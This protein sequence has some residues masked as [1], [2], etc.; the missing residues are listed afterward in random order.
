MDVLLGMCRWWTYT[1][2]SGGESCV[3][4]CHS[5][6]LPQAPCACLLCVRVCVRVYVV[7]RVE[8]HIC[9]SHVHA[10]FCCS[11]VSIVCRA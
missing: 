7:S 11:K 3:K 2:D 5:T 4:F 8:I 1:G 10:G 6:L 9:I